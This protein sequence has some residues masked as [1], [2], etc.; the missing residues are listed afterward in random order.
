MHLCMDHRHVPISFLN[1]KQLIRS[2]TSLS[3]R[4]VFYKFYLHRAAIS[5][6]S[7][8]QTNDQSDMFP[9]KLI[10]DSK[11]KSFSIGIID[12]RW[13]VVRMYLP[14]VDQVRYIIFPGLPLTAEDQNQFGFTHS[15]LHRSGSP[16]DT[17]YW[18]I[19]RVLLSA[20]GSKCR[21]TPHGYRNYLIKQETRQCKTSIRPFLTVHPHSLDRHTA[22]KLKDVDHVTEES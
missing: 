21:T 9:L 22:W 5:V 13:V 8:T 12:N 4:N 3:D 16:I 1:W 19:I 17:C 7:S 2:V 20:P 10:R 11:M 18:S 15:I 6:S 14:L